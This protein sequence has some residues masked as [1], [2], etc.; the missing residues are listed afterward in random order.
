MRGAPERSGA[1]RF[2]FAVAP[3]KRSG[4]FRPSG[5]VPFCVNRKEPKNH[6]G[7]KRGFDFECEGRILAHSVFSPRPLFLRE[8]SQVVQPPTDRRG[9]TGHAKPLIIAAAPMAFVKVCRADG[10]RLLLKLACGCGALLSAFPASPH[11][12]SGSG[13]RR[14]AS[15][16]RSRQDFC[17]RAQAK[18]CQTLLRG[19]QGIIPCAILW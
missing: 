5:R 19:T 6:L 8:R 15:Y 2:V 14:A 1:L 10:Q 9:V 11:Q 4:G 3:A 12:S 13:K 17:G 16:R 7:G 18:L